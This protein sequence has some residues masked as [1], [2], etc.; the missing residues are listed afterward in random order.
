MSAQNQYGAREVRPMATKFISRQDVIT[1]LGAAT[2]V[3]LALT[4]VT[5]PISLIWTGQPLGNAALIA[6]DTF[7]SV[8]SVAFFAAFALAMAEQPSSSSGRH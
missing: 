4:I 7:A 6:A 5:F 2:I 3:F 8:F 1:V